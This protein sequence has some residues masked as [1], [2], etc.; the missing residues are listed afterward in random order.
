MASPDNNDNTPEVKHFEPIRTAGSSSSS[1]T[2]HDD[3]NVDEA[4][5]S[6]PNH[7]HYED[8]KNSVGSS[9]SR[10][11]SFRHRQPSV[12]A[13]LRNPL[14][15]KTEEDVLADVD[16]FVE[17]KGLQDERDAFRK[18]AL[19]ARVKAQK[20][21]FDSLGALTDEE[22]QILRQEVDHRWKQPFM[23]YFLVVLCAGSAIVQGMVSVNCSVFN[24]S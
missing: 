17:K 9:P 24:L 16:D 2:V 4:E 12:S 5:K 7:G 20:Y 22:R 13:L 14:A 1:M 19:L 21:G 23:L 11:G 15:G 18:G 3:N 8:R 6:G 10:R